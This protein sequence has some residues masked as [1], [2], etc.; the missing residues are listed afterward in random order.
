MECLGTACNARCLDGMV[1]LSLVL[2]HPLRLTTICPRSMGAFIVAILSFVWRS[3][4]SNDPDPNGNITTSSRAALGPRI[5]ITCVLAL[6][7]IYFALIVK[8]LRSYGTHVFD[9]PRSLHGPAGGASPSHTPRSRARD[10]EPGLEQRGR[11][12]ERRREKG[13]TPDLPAQPVVEVVNVEADLPEYSKDAG[14]WKKNM[15]GLT[16]YGSREPESGGGG[17][18]VDL[19]KGLGQRVYEKAHL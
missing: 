10:V 14:K 15:L 9:A 7:L 11:Q 2:I 13:P 4:S 3:G 8:T 16:R 5:A 12:Q 19:E 6:G 18:D 1:R 17:E